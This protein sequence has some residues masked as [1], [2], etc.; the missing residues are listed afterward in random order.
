MSNYFRP[1]GRP[2]T[3]IRVESGSCVE[4]PRQPVRPPL[5]AMELSAA[6][7]AKAYG[8]IG[9]QLGGTVGG[10]TYKVRRASTCTWGVYVH[11]FASDPRFGR[12]GCF[13]L[14]CG[15]GVL[16]SVRQVERALHFRG[17]SECAYPK[18]SCPRFK[19]GDFRIRKTPPRAK[20][21]PA[22]RSLGC[23]Y[24]GRK[25]LSGRRRATRGQVSGGRNRSCT[26][27]ERRTVSPSGMR[28]RLPVLGTTSNASSRRSSTFVRELIP[29]R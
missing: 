14:L 25:L 22:R 27:L 11:V 17:V 8:A 5:E 18:C 20:W 28:P 19:P 29:S 10:H 21:G 24:E 9:G 7:S 23:E 4:D 3:G 12:E 13:P 2:A 6:A 16:M 1:E 26:F 15:A